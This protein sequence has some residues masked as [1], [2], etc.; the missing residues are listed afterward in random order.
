MCPA[1]HSRSIFS[2]LCLLAEAQLIAA[3]SLAA[4]HLVLGESE[5]DTIVSE[6]WLDAFQTH[7]SRAV[8]SKKSSSKS[9][10]IAAL[11][12]R[13]RRSIATMKDFV[14]QGLMTP[15][16]QDRLDVPEAISS[17]EPEA[18]PATADSPT[19]ENA[20]E[21]AAIL[22]AQMSNGLVN[23]GQHKRAPGSAAAP[24]AGLSDEESGVDAQGAPMNVGTV[25]PGRQLADLMGRDV[26]DT[27]SQ[28][29]NAKAKE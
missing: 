26:A 29:L 12:Q 7:E 21:S 20:S 28:L 25:A 9:D 1:D 6:D 5:L 19:Q 13:I 17:T 15:A 14:A 11:R 22:D 23:D 27:A 2:P 18:R 8:N 16:L 3:S 24:D 10:Q 4:A